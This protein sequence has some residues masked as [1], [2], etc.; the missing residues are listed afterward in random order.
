VQATA[1][2]KESSSKHKDQ[3]EPGAKPKTTAKEVAKSRKLAKSANGKHSHEEDQSDHKDDGRPKPTKKLK[4]SEAPEDK[5]VRP[6]NAKVPARLSKYGA[7][8]LQQT[9]LPDPSR[10]LSVTLLALVFNAMLASARISHQT[11]VRSVSYPV[12]AG[13]TTVV[14][15]IRTVPHQTGHFA[16]HN[17]TKLRCRY[18][19]FRSMCT[20]QTINLHAQQMAKTF[21]QEKE[22]VSWHTPSNLLDLFDLFYVNIYHGTYERYATV[23]LLPRYQRYR[24]SY[25]LR[26]NATDPLYRCVGQL[27]NT[28]P[29]L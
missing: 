26:T 3:K 23:P 15:Y 6:S 25:W 16:R 4:P 18:L 2:Y 24:R 11:A 14:K 8:P 28:G 20:I 19:R 13:F 10:P 29:V 27:A 7:I 22:P 17:S 9:R 5:L 12:F 1:S 21:Y